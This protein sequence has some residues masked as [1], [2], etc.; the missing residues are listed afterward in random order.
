MVLVEQGATPGGGPPPA[1]AL[2]RK[3]SRRQRL[4]VSEGS[5]RDCTE[6]ADG[7]DLSASSQL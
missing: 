6:A 1:K 5:H 3:W 2:M 7:G 4:Q